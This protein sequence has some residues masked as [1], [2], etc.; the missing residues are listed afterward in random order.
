MHVCA[1]DDQACVGMYVCCG[2]QCVRLSVRPV[3][4][5]FP[6]QSQPGPICENFKP[7]LKQNSSINSIT[8]NP[9]C[10]SFVRQTAELAVMLFFEN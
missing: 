6:P 7:A 4:F 1:A 9:F 2:S 5:H 8:H 3:W 10:S